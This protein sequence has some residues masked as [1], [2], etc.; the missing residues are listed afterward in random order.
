M[1]TVTPA[2]AAN[3]KRVVGRAIAFLRVREGISQRELGDRVGCTDQTISDYEAGRRFV[4]FPML[5][6]I[7]DALA[8]Q[9]GEALEVVA[10][11]LRD[12]H[13]STDTVR[14]R[15][16]ALDLRFRA[17]PPPVPHANSPPD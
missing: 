13:F 9:P 4:T 3:E 2:P 11:A 10:E 17:P 8:L 1:S 5:L 12:H 7:N 14:Y 15:Q 6:K 16:P